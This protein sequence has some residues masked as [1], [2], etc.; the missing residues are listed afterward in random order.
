MLALRSL[1]R[2]QAI[3]G[4]RC[5]ASQ[6]HRATGK[7]CAPGLLLLQPQ[8]GHKL[9]FS[10]GTQAAPIHE[11]PH[12]MNYET[13]VDMHLI[14]K[15]AFMDRQVQY[16]F[17]LAPQPPVTSRAPPLPRPLFGEKRQKEG[18]WHWTSY[19]DFGHLVDRCRTS[20]QEIGVT[21]GDTVACISKNRSEWAVCAYAT[22]SLGGVFVPMYEEQRPK[23]WRYI[24]EDANAKVLFVSTKAIHHDTH[25]FAG[26]LGNIQHVYCFD[27]PASDTHSFASF[28]EGTSETAPA[29]LP[30]KT[31]L[32]TLI[33]TS[34]TTGKPKGVQLSHN[35]IISNITGLRDILP[36]DLISCHDRSLSFLPWAHCYGQTAELH[37]L[38][39]HGASL[40]IAEGVDKLGDNLMET[41]P[42]VLYAV[43]TLFKKV[44]DGIHAKVSSASAAQ[45]FLFKRSLQIAH[46]R[47]MHLESDQPVGAVLAMEHKLLDKL[48]LSKVRDRFGG[49]L[50]VSFVGGAASPLEVLSF[51]EN[52]GIPICEGYGLTETSPLVTVQTTELAHRKLGTTGR[53]LGGVTVSICRDGQLCGPDEEGE[54]CVSGPNVMQGYNN[55]PDATAEVMFELDG[56]RYFRTGDLGTMVEGKY[57]RITGR[58]KEQYKLEN[59]KYV[60]PG[61]IE[62][63]LSS[64]KY[65]TQ[66]LLY[67]DNRP[68]NVALIVPDW[69]LLRAWASEKTD[70][71]PN[72]TKEE[73]ANSEVVCNLI[74]G[75][76]QGALEST[77]KYEIPKRW[78]LLEEGFTAERGMLT[79]KLSVKRHIV[80]KEYEGTIRHLY[81]EARQEFLAREA[82][83]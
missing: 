1:T 59:G 30:C 6:A 31:D 81:G 74:E 71:G 66:A 78:H 55:N 24:L 4:A 79:P 76:V 13:L 42:T 20:L 29:F 69:E 23:D 25:H 65:I 41:Q 5:A 68:F 36:E 50:K 57:L 63:A 16:N 34:G 38:M 62:A 19:K 52:I 27:E 56:E 7:A 53:Q 82:A 35:N 46:R 39:A 47:R 11:T 9:A 14:T 8:G 64:S 51:F 49:N 15:E 60:V 37:A 73:L 72:A 28:M 18:D 2:R 61:P 48:V 44:Y 77:K 80:V 45:Q 67:G 26:V 17:H 58:I 22:Y 70:L 21:R 54:V 12:Y 33:Y 83:A 3:V 40:G 32:A 75:E 43:P 10:T